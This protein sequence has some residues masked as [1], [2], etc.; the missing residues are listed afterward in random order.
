ME[1][2]HTFRGYYVIEA[3][4]SSF[5][6]KFSKCHLKTSY[7]VFLNLKNVRCCRN[8][9]KQISGQTVTEVRKVHG[10]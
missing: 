8:S 5:V 6:Y 9:K 1:I 10:L 4:T 7:K 2:N 3:M